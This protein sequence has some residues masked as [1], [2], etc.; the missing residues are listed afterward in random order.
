MIC[1]HCHAENREGAKF[2]DEC[3]TRLVLENAV[4]AGSSVNGVD[5][6]PVVTQA[7]V[8][9]EEM[10]EGEASLV[11][12][13]TGSADDAGAFE[14]DSIPCSFN[15][16]DDSPESAA[17][18]K[19]SDDQDSEDARPE[20]G[21]SMD[22]DP[23]KGGSEGRFGFDGDAQA[24]GFD[25][26]SEVFADG[27]L[28]QG[29]EACEAAGDTVEGSVEGGCS[30]D[31]SEEA[32][33]VFAK[34]DLSEEADSDKTAIIQGRDETPASEV[35]ETRRIDLSGFDSYMPE[36]S[37]HAPASAWR[38][39]GTMRMPRIEDAETDPDQKSFRAPKQR[40]GGH[41]GAKIAAIIVV[42][43]ALCAA[44]AAFATY[45]ME[46][47][48]GK[49][50]PDVVGLTQADATNMLESKGFSV[51]ATQVKSDE[52]EGIVLLMDPGSGSRMDEGGE[53]VIHVATSRQVPIVTGA[54]RA[55]AEAAVAAEGLSNVTYTTQ[56]SDGEEGVV[57]SIDP[58]EGSKVRANTPVT[59]VISEPYVVPAIAGKSQ[60]DAAEALEEAGYT[61]YIEYVYN[62][63]VPE[64]TVL[65]SDP[66]EGAKA[67]SGTSVAIEVALSRGTELINATQGILYSGATVAI[68]GVNYDVVSC[69]SVT[70]QGNETTA[71]SITAT[72]FTYF[73]G[74]KLPLEA[75]SV[76]GTITWNADNTISSSSPSLS[77][78]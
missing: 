17:E 72:P 35:S 33:V 56:R 37:W 44:I 9:S 40:K 69:D 78:G 41:K 3:G 45:Q 6:G 30:K 39:G 50:V 64:G 53:V 29:D 70:Y 58:V 75:R 49:I 21:S 15:A 73:L 46:L 47:W 43:V 23:S 61:S 66:A 62:E 14:S 36:G 77:L 20:S 18:A 4:A 27:A 38:D 26:N 59:I 19:K 34:P 76:S 57:L 71:Y 13:E 48:G 5:F 25:I 31:A 52:T 12:E 1:P 7:E 51:R 63:D 68:D 65:G 60:S 8:K 74:V 10:S 16:L 28:T 54:S 67:A 11:P 42:I 2:C 55:D 32:T 22:S 24:A